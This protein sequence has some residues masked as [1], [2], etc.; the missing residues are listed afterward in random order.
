MH[1][2]AERAE[3][4]PLRMDS[5]AVTVV[6]P[7]FNQVRYPEAALRSVLDQAAP[8]AAM[9]VMDGGRADG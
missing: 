9:I 3:P 2:D 7:S 4:R 1:S 6:I 5:P 8:G